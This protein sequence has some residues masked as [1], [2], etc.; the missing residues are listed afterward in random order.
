MSLKWFGLSEHPSLLPS[1]SSVVRHMGD[2]L[3]WYSNVDSLST[4]IS[5][6]EETILFLHEGAH[7]D[8]Y[9]VCKQLS[10]YHPLLFII[11]LVPKDK[12]DLKRAMKAGATD[13]IGLPVQEMELVTAVQEA[14]YRLQ[15]KKSSQ[16]PYPLHEKKL[17]RVMT[18]CGTKG[19]VGKTTI[20]VNLAVAFAKYN[21]KVAVVDADLQ[22]GDIAIMFDEQPK[23]TSYE[24]VK[25]QND[26]WEES[27]DKYMTHHHSGVHLLAAPIRPEFAE[28][29]TGDHMKQTIEAL[30]SVYDIVIIDTPPSLLET[31]LVAL[32]SST[33]ILLVTSMELPTLKNTKLCMQ[34]LESLGLKDR[35]KVILNR[36]TKVKGLRLDTVEQVLGEPIYL[37]IPSS[38]NVVVP[39]VNQGI[40]FVLSHPRLE[41][42]RSFFSLAAQLQGVKLREKAPSSS[43]FAKWFKKIPSRKK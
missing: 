3:Q 10:I 1:V 24:L 26:K 4:A 2:T 41:I 30:Q 20:A 13:S 36:D 25:E 28:V 40:P 34:T 19:G 32:E 18:I 27:I 23:R 12:L 15:L 42:S 29:I 35:V 33:E 39:S 31:G 43:V 16:A 9:E 7:Y 38:G 17:G 6:S 22:F 14:K 11:L 37:R 5:P 21:L 8:I